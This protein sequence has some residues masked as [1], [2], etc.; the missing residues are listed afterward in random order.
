M[1][2]G[3]RTP[4]PIDNLAEEMPD[5]SRQLMELRNNSGKVY[6]GEVAMVEADFTDELE[7]L[8]QWS[9]KAARLEVMA[10]ADTAQDAKRAFSY[11]A[12]GIGLCRTERMFNDTDRLPIVVDIIL[13]ETEQDRQS[14]L[15]MRNFSHLAPMILPRLHSYSLVSNQNNEKSR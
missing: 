3:I 15:D 1:V 12:M 8:L 11:G 5:L 13:A 10:D 4:K 14:A 6:L 9:D 2:A 7:T